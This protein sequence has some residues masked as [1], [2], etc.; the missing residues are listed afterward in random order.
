MEIG[1]REGN[2]LRVGLHRF[3]SRSGSHWRMVG[4]TYGMDGVQYKGTPHVMA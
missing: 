2:G 4:R 1:G 3:R